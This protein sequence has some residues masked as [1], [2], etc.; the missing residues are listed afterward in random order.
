MEGGRKR[1]ADMTPMHGTGPRGQHEIDRAAIAGRRRRQ[2]RR[3]ARGPPHRRPGRA[4]RRRI[5][6][7]TRIAANGVGKRR[8][9]VVRAQRAGREMPKAS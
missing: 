1:P 6:G 5:G 4:H 8:M 2:L 9:P 3:G 7:L